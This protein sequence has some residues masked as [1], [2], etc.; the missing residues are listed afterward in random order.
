M[1]RLHYDTDLIDVQWTLLENSCRLQKRPVFRPVSCRVL[2]AVW[3]ISNIERKT[4]LVIS[5]AVFEFF[6]R[7]C[8]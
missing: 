5:Y 8:A 3:R 4:D 1:T 7:Q 2:W 6:V